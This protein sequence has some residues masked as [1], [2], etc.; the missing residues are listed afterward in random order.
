[1]DVEVRFA[2]L[3]ILVRSSFFRHMSDRASVT[4]MFS[5]RRYLSSISNFRHLKSSLCSRAGASAMFSQRS[6]LVVSGRS[7]QGNALLVPRA[8][9]S[10]VLYIAIGSLLNISTI[11]GTEKL[12]KENQS[13]RKKT[14]DVKNQLKKITEEISQAQ[15]QASTKIGEHTGQKMTR[16][17]HQAKN[18]LYNLCLISLTALLL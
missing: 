6:L 15:L 18:I 8:S 9:W 1:M 4:G 3:T 14:F 12:R 17:C 11:T 7:Q 2:P 5:L 10:D 16:K 13:K